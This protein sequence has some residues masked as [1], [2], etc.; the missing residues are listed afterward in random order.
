MT[1][2]TDAIFTVLHDN[3]N[4]TFGGRI[5][6]M[7]VPDGTALPYL[8]YH[9]ITAPTELSYQTNKPY[10]ARIQFSVVGKPARAAL[11]LLEQCMV[12]LDANT[13]ALASPESCHNV[14]REGDAEPLPQEEPL[15]DEGAERVYGFFA[16]YIY[17]VSYVG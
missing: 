8:V 2:L 5:Y 17:S 6:F 9:P 12:V 15:R 11:A 3:L 14:L 1:K 7:D 10:D 16:E 4:S 13:P